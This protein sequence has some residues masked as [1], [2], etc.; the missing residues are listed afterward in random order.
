LARNDNVE[1]SGCDKLTRR[2]NQQKPVQ[3]LTEKYS[4]FAVGQITDLSSRVSTRWGALR[5][6]TNARWDAVD[7]THDERT[8]IADGEV[9]W[10]WRPDAGAKR[11]SNIA[12]RRWQESPV[13]GESSK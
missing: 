2:A 8:L 5:N 7:A 1:A 6:V 10:S 9:V 12:R 13:T 11:C 3:P 4:A